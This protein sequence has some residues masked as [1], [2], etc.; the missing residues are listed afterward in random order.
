VSSWSP[1]EDGRDGSSG[2]SPRRASCRSTRRALRTSRARGGQDGASSANVGDGGDVIG[3]RRVDLLRL[4]SRHPV[5]D[6]IAGRIRTD[7]RMVED[8]RDR[9]DCL[10]D[11]SGL[12]VL[13]D[14]VG[15]KLRDV[16][17]GDLIDAPSPA[18]EA[19]ASA[20]WTAGPA[21]TPRRRSGTRRRN[22]SALCSYGI[23]SYLGLAACPASASGEVIGS[24]NR[25]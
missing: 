19:R 9:L 18:A 5:D 1:S 11:R 23:Q 20:T 24:C 10:L 21:W 14:E 13:R 3:S 2:R 15:H 25:R 12:L 8:H 16:A 6:A 17:R 7:A 4:L 22:L